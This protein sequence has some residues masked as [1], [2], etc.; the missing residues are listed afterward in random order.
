MNKILLTGATGL[1]GKEAIKPLIDAGYEIFALSSNEQVERSDIKWVKANLFCHDEIK[2]ILETLKPTH[3]LHFAWMASGDYLTSETNY[4]FVDASMNLLEAFSQNGGYRA[5]FAGTCFEYEFKDEP[6]KETDELNPQTVYATCK[7]ELRQR[8]EDFCEKNGIDFG[9]GRIFYVY[10]HGENEKRL[11]PHLINSLKEG[12]EVVI[13]NGN[14]IKDYMY[15]KDVAGSFVK[16]LDTNVCGC[17]NI[18]TGRGISLGEYAGLI[19]KKLGREDLLVVKNEPTTQPKIIIGDNSRLIN[20]VEYKLK[21]EMC[22]ALELIIK[23]NY[24]K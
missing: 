20:E 19:A 13:N 22:D 14:L 5:V 7:N 11:T 2:N 8:A 24:K 3:M 1:I 15:T 6:L 9:W 23:Y 12:R 17:V 18:C 21:Y 10:G 4:K 16:F